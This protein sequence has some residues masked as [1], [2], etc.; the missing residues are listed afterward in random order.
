MSLLPRRLRT[1]LFLSYAVVVAS[2]AV[3]MVLVGAAVT[4]T[5]YERRIGGFGLGQGRGP[6]RNDQVSTPVDETQ[7]AEALD[8]S[9]WRALLAGTGAAL[10]VAA[11][12][13]WFVGSRLL[14]PLDEVRG[15]TRRMAAGDYSVRVDAP[16][17][18][19][20]ASLAEDVNVLGQHLADTERRRSQLLGE[21]AHEMRTPLTVIG[22]HLEGLVDGVIGPT[23]RTF[24]LLAD[25]AKRLERL[26]DDLTLLSRAD[27]GTLTVDLRPMDLATVVAG[28]VARLAPQYE[29]AGVHLDH[30]PSGPLPVVGDDQRLAQV[31]TN[32]LGNA[33][34]HTP[35]G[36]SV[37]VRAGRDGVTWVE[38]TDTG[39][40]FATD[41]T[42]A[43]F[44]RF[45]RA[46]SASGRSGR[47]I[48]LTIAR[49]LARAHGGDVTASSAGT[50]RGATFRLTLPN[51]G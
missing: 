20:L 48:G 41:Q 47:G 50:G 7:L 33:L 2:G 11:I 34:E 38:I 19:E 30:P 4:R 21:V 44:E 42:E 35:A 8:A 9:L 23:D 51:G 25:E 18:R 22:G 16:A 14:R 15:A 36:G 31:L 39:D 49:S 12:V 45:H 5:V 17:E 1:R 40:G 24:V 46:P 10:V 6:G 26:V 27:E 43:I 29:H 28:V 32:V 37:T 13:A 3:A